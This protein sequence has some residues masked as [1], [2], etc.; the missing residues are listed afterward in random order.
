MY[1][2]SELIKKINEHR[3]DINKDFNRS[4]QPLNNNLI[5][6]PQ[7]QK[8]IDYFENNENKKYILPTSEDLY[9]YCQFNLIM[10]NN[11]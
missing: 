2:E 11:Q 4:S 10:N 1:K 3:T 7:I 8:I 6:N 9:K 5:K